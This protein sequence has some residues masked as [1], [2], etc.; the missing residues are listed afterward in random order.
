MSKQ[1]R[2]SNLKPRG[3]ETPPADRVAKSA[4]PLA[5]RLWTAVAVGMGAAVVAVLR[6]PLSAVVLALLLASKGGLATSPLIIVAVVVAYLTTLAA[7]RS[8]GSK[9]AAAAPG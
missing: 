4:R 1:K 9:A 6:L 7:T 8:E 5:T 3:V 2:T